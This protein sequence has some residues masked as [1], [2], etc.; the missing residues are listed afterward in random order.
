MVRAAKNY[1]DTDVFGSVQFCLISLLCA[2]NFWG[3]GLC[4]KILPYKL[5][6][7]SANFK[8]CFFYTFKTFLQILVNVWHRQVPEKFQTLQYSVNLILNIWFS[9]KSEAFN[10]G[11]RYFF[12]LNILYWRNRGLFQKLQLWGK[13]KYQAIPEI[14]WNT[15]TQYLE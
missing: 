6:Q 7:S 12:R 8:F 1:T 14:I 4:K 9:S 10:F 3:N 2:I 5:F 13:K 15:T 11:W